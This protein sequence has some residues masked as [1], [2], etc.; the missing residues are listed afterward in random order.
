M[1]YLIDAWLDKGDP[2][3]KITDADSGAVRL[4]WAYRRAQPNTGDKEQ[5][6]VNGSP[7]A[8]CSALH[9]LVNHLFLLACADRLA[10]TGA[11]VPADDSHEG[12]YG[13]P[14]SGAWTQ[15]RPP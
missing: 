7:C 8:G 4:L 10:C 13:A 1:R 15:P 12:R 2:R 6:C 5:G 9:C 11:A 3:L 14:E